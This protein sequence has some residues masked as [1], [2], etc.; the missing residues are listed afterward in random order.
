MAAPHHPC[1]ACSR[2]PDEIPI[3][4]AILCP[5]CGK[6][7]PLHTYCG[8]CGTS[9]KALPRTQGRR[10]RRGILGRHGS[11]PCASRPRCLPIR[12]AA[13]PLAR[14]SPWRLAGPPTRRAPGRA[15]H[16]RSASRRSAYRCP[17]RPARLA[18]PGGT[19]DAVRG[20][21]ARRRRHRGGVR[22][23]DLA[24]SRQSR[25]PGQDPALLGCRA[26]RVS[27]A[28]ARTR[29]RSDVPDGLPFADRTAYKDE[30]AGLRPG[31]RRQHLEISQQ[32]AGFLI[33]SALGTARWRSSSRAARPTSSPRS[34]CSMRAAVCCEGR[35]LGYTTDDDAARTLL[36]RPILGHRT[37]VGGL[38]GGALDSSQGPSVDFSV[39]SVA[40]D[41]RRRSRHG[42]HRAGAGGGPRGGPF[43]SRT[44]S[45]TASRG[46]LTR[47]SSEHAAPLL[48][49][50]ALDA[51]DPACGADRGSDAAAPGH[52]RC[53]RVLRRTRLP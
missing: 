4:P 52:C 36:G 37:G 49:R 30:S 7:T 39:A 51:H 44:R 1:R 41:R 50:S 31:V 22:V 40:G 14:G 18:R 25:L 38:F 17:A 35:L 11:T 42:H 53:P 3:G 48:D 9:L 8:N 15:A 5:E 12:A 27:A 32:D 23:R 46:P 47:S 16:R 19:A 26:G 34:S 13:P 43:P 24:G 21:H 6:E 28:D 29:P 33:L 45:S 10:V 20:G 2:K